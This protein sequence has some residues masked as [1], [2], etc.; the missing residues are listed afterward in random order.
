MPAA[1]KADLEPGRVYR[2]RDLAH[3]SANPTRYAHRLVRDR[4]LQPLAPGLY[5]HPK[6][7]RFGTVPPTTE[8]ILR[9]FLTGGPYVITGP[10][11]WNALGLGT[12]AVLSA[13]LVYNTKRS[14]EFSLGGRPFLFRRVAF[15]QRPT[16][17]WFAIDLLEHADMAGASRADLEA[18]L[19][20]SLASHKFDREALREAAS[21]YGTR[22]TRQRVERAIAQAWSS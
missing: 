21:T 3:W 6:T 17:E 9:G 14:G 7:S 2:T 16:A 15:P 22:A 18:S 10:E 8:E 4:V 13:T 11:K 12:T 5:V 20:A 1:R 19:A